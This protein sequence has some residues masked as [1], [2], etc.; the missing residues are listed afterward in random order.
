VT[1]DVI[2]FEHQAT[3]YIL[4]SQYG[5]YLHDDFSSVGH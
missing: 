2:Y 4:F 3:F 1:E 5:F